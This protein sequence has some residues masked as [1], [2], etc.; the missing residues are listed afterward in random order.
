MLGHACLLCETEDVRILTD[1][2]LSGPA[3]FRSWWHLPDEQI[4]LKTLPG[5]D[6]IYISHLHEDH[7]HPPTLVG[8]EQRPKVLIPRLYHNRLARHLRRL[9]YTSI[10]ELPHDKQV[11]LEGSTWVCCVQT[12]NDSMLL[13]GDSSATMLNANDALQGNDPTI[14]IPLLNQLAGRHTLDIAFLAFGTA[15][16]FPKCYHFEDPRE[17]TDPRV[18]ER[19]MLSTFVRGALAAKAKMVVPFAGGFALLENR[20][21]WMNE[22]KSTPKDAIEALRAKSKSQCALEMNPGD[23]WDSR[24]GMTQIHST[25]DWSSK[26]QMIQEMRRMHAQ[27]LADIELRDRQGPQDLYDLFRRRLTQNL[28]GFPYLRTRMN[29]A[30]LFEV[31]GSPGGQWEVDLRK[32]SGWFREGDS[33]DWLMRI[34]IPSALFA[35]VLAD[36]DGWETLG[37]SYK[38]N[39]TMKKGAL[40][41]E[42]LLNRLIH[43]PTPF[44][45]LR[46]LLTPRFAEFVLRRRKEFS[47]L[48]QRKLLAPA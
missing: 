26:L 10:I 47:K 33:G 13:V 19:A 1:P 32:P 43:T 28:R 7:F 34:A 3:N 24:N 44:G 21:M 46:L 41:K 48:L 27:E 23:I 16:A 12:G 18:K 11:R 39:V 25:I 36:P 15:G 42:G 35:H 5:L 22:A 14:T 45:A 37:I 8:L 4:K 40:A 38:L 31:E 20:L 29:C 6:Y 30:V 2:W 17:G 9:G